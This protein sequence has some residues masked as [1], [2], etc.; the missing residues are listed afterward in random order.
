[1]TGRELIMKLLEMDKNLP[2]LDK[3]VNLV[4]F[5]ENKLK[6]GELKKV[7]DVKEGIALHCVI[8]E[9]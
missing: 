3:K 5:K 9:D 7:T 2:F 6:Y 4:F 1:M 8:K